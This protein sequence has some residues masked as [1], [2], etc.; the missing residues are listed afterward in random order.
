ML[1]REENEGGKREAEEERKGKYS[2]SYRK[3]TKWLK[4]W[5]IGG[6]SRG[7]CPGCRRGEFVST[8]WCFHSLKRGFG[9]D[10]EGA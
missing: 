7:K 9:V 10:V 2:P 3:P 5:E 4:C 8:W 6:G 1:F